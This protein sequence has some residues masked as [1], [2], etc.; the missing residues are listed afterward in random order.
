MHGRMGQDSWD[1]AC[2]RG[3]GGPGDAEENAAEKEITKIL[4]HA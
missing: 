3:L 1:D 4:Q 2:L